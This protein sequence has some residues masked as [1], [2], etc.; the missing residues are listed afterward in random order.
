MAWYVNERVILCTNSSKVFGTGILTH[1][2]MAKWLSGIIWNRIFWGPSCT[3]SGWWFGTFFIFP[4]FP[5]S[6]EC[7]HPNWFFFYI[8][9]GSQP[10][11]FFNR[12]PWRKIEVPKADQRI[13]GPMGFPGPRELNAEEVESMVS[14]PWGNRACHGISSCYHGVN[15]RLATNSGRLIFFGRDYHRIE[16]DPI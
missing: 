6:W 1:S 11:G 3:D 2:H 12:G 7:H 16:V 15:P 14:C 5:F 9:R 13:N 10:P 4:I 8:F